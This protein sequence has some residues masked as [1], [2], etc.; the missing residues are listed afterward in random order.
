[1]VIELHLHFQPN[2]NS[3]FVHLAR[4]DHCGSI[5]TADTDQRLLRRYKPDRVAHIPHS[6]N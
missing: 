1:V 6:R 3:S 5:L 4:P 2:R